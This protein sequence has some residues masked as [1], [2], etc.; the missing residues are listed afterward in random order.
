MALLTRKVGQYKAPVETKLLTREIGLGYNDI[1]GAT[2]LGGKLVAGATSKLIGA[3]NF[4]AGA[5]DQLTGNTYAAEKRY[6]E[7]DANAFSKKLDKMYQANGAM[8]FA[9]AVAE[10]VGQNIPT[11]LISL[12]PVVGTATATA[13]N[14]AGY[15][16]LGVQSAYEKTGK[17]GAKEYAYGIATGTM[18]SA[19]EYI[20]GKAGGWLGGS[21]LGTSAINMAGKA[22]GAVASAAASAG[23]LGLA[24]IGGNIVKGGASE[25]A[26]EFV[27]SYAEIFLQRALQIDPEAQY[28]FKDALY[29]G[30]VGFASGGVMSGT[31]SVLNTRAM[32][33]VGDRVMKAGEVDMTI[34]AAREVASAFKASGKLEAEAL[35]T[36][37]DNLDLFEKTAD[38]TG[39]QAKMLL[40]NIRLAMSV[41]EVYAGEAGTYKALAA[42][43]EKFLPYA[44]AVFGEQVT[45]ADIANPD[46]RVA[47]YIAAANWA[48]GEVE[49]YGIRAKKATMAE[50]VAAEKEGRTKPVALAEASWQGED[51][52][53]TMPDGNR[54]FV[55]GKNGNHT[56]MTGPDTDNVQAAANAEGST[57]LS[58]AEVGEVLE[59]LRAASAQETIVQGSHADKG[60]KSSA[61]SRL[62]VNRLQSPLPSTEK[63]TASAADATYTAQSR[64]SVAHT[65]KNSIT[66]SSENV[67]GEARKAPE[68]GEKTENNAQREVSES[69]RA[70]KAGAEKP[71]TALTDAVKRTG[72]RLMSEY[73]AS[74]QDRARKLLRGVDRLSAERR[75]AIY[76]LIQSAANTPDDVLRATVAF[77]ADRRGL[78]LSFNRDLNASLDKIVTEGL[79]RASGRR[80]RM[81]AIAKGV[82]GVRQAVAHEIF[83]DIFRTG[84]GKDLAAYAI[85]TGDEVRMEGTAKD[86]TALFAA[87]DGSVPTF[88]EFRQKHKG[89]SLADAIRAYDEQYAA[90]VG[91]TLTEEVAAKE[92]GAKLGTKR[93]MRVLADSKGINPVLRV[94]RRMRALLSERKEKGAY[95]DEVKRLEK[96]FLSAARDAEVADTLGEMAEQGRARYSIV[97][98]DNGM[99]YVVASED[100]V[101]KGDDATK[102]AQ[103]V[104]NYINRVIRG[105]QDLVIKTTQGDYLTI[106]RDTA[107]KA[108]FR[109]QVRNP[110]GTYRTMTDAEYKVKLNAEIHI[111]ELAQVSRKGNKPNEPDHKSHRFAKDGFTYRTAYFKDFDGK[112]YK[113]TISVGENG[114]VSTVYNVGKIKEDTLPSGK[115]K[116]TFSGSKANNV[117]S[118]NSI[119][120]NSEKSTPAGQKASGNA[121][122]GRRSVA[123][124]QSGELLKARAAAKQERVFSRED[125]ASIAAEL[126]TEADIVWQSKARAADLL[127]EAMNT[128]YRDTL[129]NDIK[130]ATEAIVREARV[131]ENGKKRRLTDT[132]EFELRDLFEA[133][134]LRFYTT[135]G[136]ET[137]L[138]RARGKQR[139]AQRE[140][141]FARDE[142]KVMS[143]RTNVIAY[144]V[145]NARELSEMVTKR[146][147]V[148]SELL[149][150]PEMR[151][152]A[153]L[154]AKV[155]TRRGIRE[156]NVREVARLLQGW[157][158]PDRICPEQLD[159][160]GKPTDTAIYLE[161]VRERIDGLANGKG[162]L[163]YGELGDLGDVIAHVKKIYNDYDK[164]RLEGKNVS[165]SEAAAREYDMLN[166]YLAWSEKKKQHFYDKMW[167]SV[168]NNYL[169]NIMTPRQVIASL[170][171]YDKNGTMSK[172]YA[173][174]QQG[175][176]EANYEYATMLEPLDRFLSEHKKFTKHLSK[177]TL[178]Y[179]GAVLTYGQAMALFLTSKREQAKLGFEETGFSYMGADGAVHKMGPR[180]VERIQS[181]LGAAF[182]DEDREY[183]ALVER[184]FDRAR[185]LKVEADVE[186][187]GFTNVE[188]GFYFPIVR[189]EMVRGRRTADVRSVYGG[190]QVVSNKSF[191]KEIKKGA[192]Q[193]LFIG[194]VSDIVSTHA[195]GVAAYA[196]LYSPLQTWDKVYNKAVTDEDGK[197]IGTVRELM[198]DRI[199]FK[200]GE[201]GAA[202]KYF[203][204]LF[205]DIQGVGPGYEIGDVIY[206]NLRSAYVSS[207]LGL[208]LSS[209]LKQCGSYGTASLY[210]SAGDLTRALALKPD[211]ELMFQYSKGAKGRMFD[212]GRILEAETNASVNDLWEVLKKFSN[213]TMAGVNKM[214]N[215]I[216]ARLFNACRLY[217]ERTEGLDR[218]SEENLTKAGKMLDT[219]IN[220]TQSTNTADTRSALQRGGKLAQTFSM[221]S[222]DAVKTVSYIYEALMKGYMARQRVK[223]GIGSESDV[224]EANRFMKRAGIALVTQMTVTVAVIQLIKWLLGRERD[225]DETLAEDIAGEYV[226]GAIGMLP[227]ISDVYDLFS[228]GYE[229]ENFAISGVNDLFT[230]TKSISDMLVSSS[231]GEYTPTETIA[232][233]W[234]NLLVAVGNVSGLPLRNVHNYTTGL[235]K[236]FAPTQTY[237]YYSLF[238]SNNYEADLTKA[239]NDGNDRLAE[240]VIEIIY[241]RK[242][243][244]NESVAAAEMLSL[245]KEGYEVLGPN[246]PT[247]YKGVEL[248]KEER[249]RVQSIYTKADAVV[250]RMVK[251]G[252][253]DD[254]TDKEKAKA[255]KN[256]YSAYLAK[257]K[258]EVF[259]EKRTAATLSLGLMDDALLCTVLGRISL[260]ESTDELTKA[261]QVAAY[262]NT[263]DIGNDE[264]YIILFAAG[265]TNKSVQAAMKRILKKS[266]LDDGT[267][268]AIMEKLS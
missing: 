212:K 180:S 13:V 117:S 170:E 70:Q 207:A 83:H 54:V 199:W 185:E 123:S 104:A 79:Y 44:K 87:S 248:T 169:F 259:G 108:G 143:R 32:A 159:E 5:F 151:E 59:G 73:S 118:A 19:F 98:L 15:S 43:P 28:S 257:A 234:K 237:P 85:D 31:T 222:S 162:E 72:E 256:A 227:I 236:R 116:S 168:K 69:T 34:S 120:Q 161:G 81:V 166:G 20:G 9:G 29:A 50:Y 150:A 264:R 14:V 240:R 77:L 146:K 177:E 41:C 131:L 182:S 226:G 37:K 214:D 93:F 111:N 262:L 201:R 173:D 265:Y 249:R 148:K 189:D 164:M 97:E 163:S 202:D 18:E 61:N 89:G 141:R 223:M 268:S 190:M 113:L 174:V 144:V 21:K 49:K 63:D 230:A 245:C 112:Y 90:K 12:V 244:G 186:I 252:A 158:T 126:A 106:T 8:Q 142:M 102:W 101:I 51:A 157:Y 38:K 192:K 46:S 35:G 64:R 75:V 53:Y 242:K 152:V 57:V 66:D 17:L 155:A 110:D 218:H 25:F 114:N 3:F 139:A 200:K 84:A 100:Q 224:A 94:L 175:V 198:N 179:D 136:K 193:R 188:D 238:G 10:G 260:M 95:T 74:V 231:R 215:A 58:E 47:R 22:G 96:L 216:V 45:V 39:T 128:V 194:D 67:N 220:E 147:Y 129:E 86:Y 160:N 52:V 221:F 205:S 4:V 211:Y 153:K 65:T 55:V 219:L 246:T 71:K 209:M 210:L 124:G 253:Y 135:Y 261:E 2:Y 137:E 206:A 76:E 229:I 27:E 26:E 109:N 122:E 251:L 40:G 195:Q 196:R 228:S 121:P 133:E 80:A 42:N 23:K 68:S 156:E 82:T 239:I 181:E 267:K 187:F 134:F 78:F 263:L 191:N 48:T 132:E 213:A 91:Q 184:I 119:S 183:L 232:K 241:K 88:E 130:T 11:M 243:T 154:L 197:V 266:K 167:G 103:Q 208:N 16:G 138:G 258:H 254:L 33:N 24:T 225:E 204:K 30:A 56:V 115:I 171:F 250:E 6:A 105:G 176:I 99:Q 107:Y 1:N 36:L 92:I 178:E 149:E 217:Y 235:G 233:T 125:G 60:E 172:I 62:K 145:L 203:T 255:I 165:A 127:W 140:S 247:S 7:N